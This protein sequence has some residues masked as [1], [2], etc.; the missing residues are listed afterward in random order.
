MFVART[1]IIFNT[2]KPAM[3]KNENYATLLPMLRESKPHW[4]KFVV[5][6]TSGADNTYIV[7]FEHE[8]YKNPFS[9]K[10]IAD[11]GKTEVI[12]LYPC[13]NILFEL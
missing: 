8:P 12:N 3:M 7:Y 10:Y 11:S 1:P 4:A 13:K 6:E 5:I 9:G 2:Q